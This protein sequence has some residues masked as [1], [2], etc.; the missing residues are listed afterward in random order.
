M[1]VAIFNEIKAPGGSGWT[2]SSGNRGHCCLPDSLLDCSEEGEWLA[3]RWRVLMVQSPV[4][5]TL[6]DAVIVFFLYFFNDVFAA[7]SFNLHFTPSR[8][9]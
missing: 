2:S 3:R 1:L 7:S 4:S 6:V 5:N 9:F 8:L